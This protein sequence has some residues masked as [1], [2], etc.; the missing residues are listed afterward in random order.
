ML[1]RG[2]IA[3][4]LDGA[5]VQADAALDVV[6][7]RVLAHHPP[8]T[9]ETVKLGSGPMEDVDLTSQAAS[10]HGHGFVALPCTEGPSHGRSP[11]C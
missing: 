6:L 10:A 8:G 5:V 7:R 11:A 9:A 4:A 1:P 3:L 2:K